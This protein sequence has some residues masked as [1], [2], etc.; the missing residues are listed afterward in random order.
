MKG[1]HT[2]ADKTDVAERIKELVA[3][4]LGRPKDEISD[5][6]SFE[7]DLGADSLDQVEIMMDIEDEFDLNIPEEEAQNIKNVGE[8]IRY[9]KEHAGNKSQKPG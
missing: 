8:A 6:K 5:E 2:V 4:K 3:E 7:T 9:V 1:D